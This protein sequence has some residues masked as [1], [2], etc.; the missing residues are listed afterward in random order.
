MLW[1]AIVVSAIVIGC[2]AAI[3][4]FMGEAGAWRDYMDGRDDDQ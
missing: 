3:V 2:F 1:P 4:W